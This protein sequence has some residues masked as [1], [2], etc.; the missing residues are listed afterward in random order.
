LVQFRERDILNP[1]KTTQ[2][3]RKGK[4]SEEILACLL[5]E[6]VPDT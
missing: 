4:E 6:Y 1:N 3:G 2:E 5:G